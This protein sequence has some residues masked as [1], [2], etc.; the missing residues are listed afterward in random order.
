MG[1]IVK[2]IFHMSDIHV[3]EYGVTIEDFRDILDK[4]EKT[5]SDCISPLL[6]ITG[7]LTSE[8]LKDEYEYFQRGIDGFNL[9]TVIIPGNHDERNYGSIHF[10]KLFGERFKIF[11]DES[12]VLYGADTAEPDND[13]GHL[14]RERYPQIKDLF[15]RAK[16]KIRILALHHHLLPVPH[17]GREHNVL[18]DAGDVLGV[19]DDSG[20]SLVLSGH[21]HVPWI[22]RLNDIIFCTT[23]TLL[24]RRIRGATSQLHTRI[25][26]T[27]EDATFTLCNKD[28]TEN[29]W[30]TFSIRA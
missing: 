6:V 8:G 3:G 14:G 9:P 1:K 29:K 28:G 16:D 12:I 15:G 22:W 4:I 27:R 23:G 24:S 19:L 21:R 10:E 5:A 26:L 18:E 11:E 30:A 2:T 20:C 13:A 25:E 17:T 7:D